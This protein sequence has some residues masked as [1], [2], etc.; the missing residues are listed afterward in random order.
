MKKV[1][2]SISSVEELE[3]EATEAIE[4][5]EDPPEGADPTDEDDP[6]IGEDGTLVVETEKLEVE[7]DF[8]IEEFPEET[9]LYV[10]FIGWDDTEELMEA[11]HGLERHPPAEVTITLKT[12]RRTKAG[13]SVA[14]YA[15]SVESGV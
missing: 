1:R 5:Y 15:V 14:L 8:P 4:V 12:K 11:A 3:E 2:I 9:S 13:K 10:S 7:A 6:H